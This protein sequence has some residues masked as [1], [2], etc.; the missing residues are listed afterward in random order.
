MK[1]CIVCLIEKDNKNFNKKILMCKKCI[2]FIKQ[3]NEQIYI[4]GRKICLYCMLEQELSSFRNLRDKCK[5][6]TKIQKKVYNEENKEELK[7]IRQKYREENAEEIA[8]KQQQYDVNRAQDKKQYYIDNKEY[9]LEYHELYRATHQEEI[10]AY[11][12]KPE[13]KK[14]RNKN[15][16]KNREENPSERLRHNVSSD[17]YSFLKNKGLSKGSKSIK[18]Y[19]GEDYFDRLKIHLESLFVGDKSW[20]NWDN[21]GAYNINYKTWQLDHIIPHSSFNYNFM[22]DDE[23]KECWALSNLQPL[24]ALENMKKGNKII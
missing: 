1:T 8:K 13:T 12:Q 4:I 7:K 19:L 5:A 23:F 3:L 11:N 15:Q 18:E 2:K 9:F 22:E 6:C 17:I 10:K 16:V 20:C 24:D 14:R 21:Y